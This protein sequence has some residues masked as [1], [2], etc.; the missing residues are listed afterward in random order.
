MK[1]YHYT[2]E[3]IALFLLMADMRL[4]EQQRVFQSIWMWDKDSIPIEYRADFWAFKRRVEFE[5]DKLNGLVGNV[6]ELQVILKD[7]SDIKLD[8]PADKYEQNVIAHYFKFIR[9]DLCYGNK[10]YRK[11]KLKRLLDAF[12]YRRRSQ[13]LVEHIESTLNRLDL[14]LYVK[15]NERCRIADVTIHKMLVIRLRAMSPSTG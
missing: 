12:G 9:L 4:S 1:N 10:L 14:K 15:N 13:A 3:D 8:L 11:I 2:A 5:L 6:N 7:F